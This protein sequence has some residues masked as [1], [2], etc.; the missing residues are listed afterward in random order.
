ML[1]TGLLINRKNPLEKINRCSISQFANN[2]SGWRMLREKFSRH[3]IGSVFCHSMAD[4]RGL[5]PA[6]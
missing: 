2:I 4:A 6:E 3:L 1:R 5:R